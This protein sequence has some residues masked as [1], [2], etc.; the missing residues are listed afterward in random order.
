MESLTTAR[1]LSAGRVVV[2]A[3]M[4][5]A[6]AHAVGLW[7]GADEADR[8]A[9]RVVVRAFGAREVFLGMLGAHVASRP[10]VGRRTLSGLGGL[11]AFDAVLSLA[12]ARALPARGVGL[13][14]A[15]AGGSALAHLRTSRALP[16]A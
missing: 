11:D 3:A 8:P 4:V 9:T 16:E 10:G 5:L 15:M 1:A 6:P 14:F 7:I 13:V 2:G 12:S